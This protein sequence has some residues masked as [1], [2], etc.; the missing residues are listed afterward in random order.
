[1]KPAFEGMRDK[2]MMFALPVATEVGML[3]YRKDLFEKH[4]VKVPATM[5]EL[6]QAA[7]TLTIKGADGKVEV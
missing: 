4:G 3:F 2:G 5:D 1:M 7:K 6:E